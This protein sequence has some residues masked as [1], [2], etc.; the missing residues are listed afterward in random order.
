MTF[1]KK[2]VLYYATGYKTFAAT[3][4]A[5]EVKEYQEAQVK[6]KQIILASLSMELGQRVLPKT[7]ASEM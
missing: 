4:S 5:V 1:E 3:A 6:I 2:S 7:T